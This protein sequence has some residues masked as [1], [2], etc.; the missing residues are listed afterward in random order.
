MTSPWANRSHDPHVPTST[1][2]QQQDRARDALRM[3]QIP[4]A[5]GTRATLTFD[6][7]LTG[8]N[9]AAVAHLQTLAAG[10]APTYLWGPP[11]SGKSHLLH[12]TLQRWIAQGG[13][14]ASFG[15]GDAA[16]WPAD[17]AATLIAL[18][19][20]DAYD[21][22]QQQSAFAL[23]IDAA[24]RGAV[25]VAAGSVPP[26]DLPLRDDL[27]SR[28]GWGPVY[29]LQ[30]LGEAESR[31]ALRREADRRGVL[32]SDEVIDYLLTRFARDLTHLMEQIERLDTFALA[33][34]R[35]I[36]VPLL[37]RMLTEEGAPS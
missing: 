18:D 7:Y 8:A 36:T 1:P 26:V 3:K 21:D 11:G 10:A 31:A 23:F 12:A 9:A 6:N 2:P 4:L 32:L 27:R 34:K 20:C 13:R 29:A 37:R 5:I 28:L 17:G 25:V 24:A 19:D 35:A 22:A 16:P 15:A 14:A 33:E 30:P